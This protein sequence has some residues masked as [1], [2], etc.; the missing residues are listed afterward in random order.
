M[1]CTW[2]YP[3]IWRMGKVLFSQVCVCPHPVG[4]VPHLHPIILLP[5]GYL[6]GQDW[7][8]PRPKKKTKQTEHHR[9]YLVRGEQYASCAE[10]GGLSSLMW[11]FGSIKKKQIKRNLLRQLFLCIGCFFLKRH[12]QE[13][14]MILNDKTR[15]EQME[16]AFPELKNHPTGMD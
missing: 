12:W 10:A 1:K 2:C 7:G 9:E 13:V 3:R 5:L 4:G 8:T 16:N 6:L 15:L 14:V 11:N